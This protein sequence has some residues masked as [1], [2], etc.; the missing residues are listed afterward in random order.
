[1]ASKP[2]ATSIPGDNGAPMAR[3]QLGSGLHVAPVVP[4]VKVA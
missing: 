1:M 3:P 2:G 4:G